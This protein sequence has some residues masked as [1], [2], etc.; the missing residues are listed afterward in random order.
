MPP[1]ITVLGGDRQFLSGEAGWTEMFNIRGTLR[2]IMPGKKAVSEIASN[3]HH[4]FIGHHQH[5]PQNIQNNSSYLRHTVF[6]TY[7][8]PPWNAF[9][10]SSYHHHTFVIPS[11]YLHHTFLKSISKLVIPSSYLRRTFVIPSSNLRH[12]FVIPSSYNR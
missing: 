12:T 2:D 5:I 7:L 9:Q 1:H 10:N 3:I 4:P 6:S 11:M 8:G